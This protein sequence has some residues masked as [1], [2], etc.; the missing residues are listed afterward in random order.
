MGGRGVQRGC[1]RAVEMHT[2]KKKKKGH[3]KRN[4]QKERV[5]KKVRAKSINERNGGKKKKTEKRK[6]E[7][8]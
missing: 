5:K 6:N 8:E 4:G 7:T 1:R 2:F 3:T